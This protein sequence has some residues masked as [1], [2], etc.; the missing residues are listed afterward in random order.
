MLWAPLLGAVSLTLVVGA[1]FILGGMSKA[2]RS[3]QLRDSGATGWLLFDAIISAI[4]GIL[5]LA[6]LPSTAFV[7]LGIFVGLDLIIG[8]ITMIGI[9]SRAKGATVP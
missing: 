3:Y 7:S 8:G 1:C 5:L 4:L 9:M 6:G 2:I